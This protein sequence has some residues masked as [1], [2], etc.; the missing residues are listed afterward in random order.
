MKIFMQARTLSKDGS[1]IV[2]DEVYNTTISG[3]G[4]LLAMFGT[5]ILIIQS[6]AM[7]KPWQLLSFSVYGFGA[8]NLFFLSA[9]HHGV[10]STEQVEY[11]LRRLDYYA[12]FIMIAGSVTPFCLILLRNPAGFGI[13][14]LI[15]FV[16][17]GGI[18]LQVKYP[19]LPRWFTTA[20][21]VGMGWIGA[22]IV[23]RIWNLLPWQAT[24]LLAL[25]GL[26]YTVG[27][28]L[29]VI[30]RPNPFPGKFGFHEIWHLCVLS[31]AALH[32]AIMYFYLLPY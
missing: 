32:F 15:W 4:T 10:N 16:A 13:L 2:T 25:G 6:I 24:F 27:A 8:I 30:E 31:G 28:V 7:G 23:F 18:A 20:Q 9:I 29:Y 21:Y 1:K 14:G 17:L 19:N 3:L 22:I 26:V 12:I 5:A 11:L